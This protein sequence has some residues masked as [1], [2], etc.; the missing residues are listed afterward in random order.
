MFNMNSFSIISYLHDVLKQ[1]GCEGH[2]LFMDPSRIASSTYHDDDRAQAI[3]NRMSSLLAGQSL[4][5]PW[6][7]G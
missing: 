3:A 5:I 4:F 1:R 2:I 7:L 6:N